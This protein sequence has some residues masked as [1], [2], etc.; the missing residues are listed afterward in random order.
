MPS[1]GFHGTARVLGRHCDRIWSGGQARKPGPSHRAPFG[2]EAAELYWHFVDVIWLILF[3]ILY[4][5][6]NPVSGFSGTPESCI[7]SPSTQQ[8]SASRTA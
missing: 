3:G 5:P 6:L 7:A 2:V 4:Y 1:R 8:S